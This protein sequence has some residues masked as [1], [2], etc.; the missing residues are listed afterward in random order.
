MNGNKIS[1]TDLSPAISRNDY[2]AMIKRIY[3]KTQQ[4]GQTIA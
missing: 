2:K 4:I 1:S 3:S